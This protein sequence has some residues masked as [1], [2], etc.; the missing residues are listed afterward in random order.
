M[1]F[2]LI[3]TVIFFIVNSNE[4]TSLKKQ[5][6][7]LKKQLNDLKNTANDIS[8]Q[9]ENILD[10]SKSNLAELNYSIPKSSLEEPS[11]LNKYIHNEDEEIS[12]VDSKE[13]ED[14]ST[15][16]EYI[17]SEKVEVSSINS[18]DMEEIE[19][20]NDRPV[21]ETLMQNIPEQ[22]HSNNVSKEPVKKDYEKIVGKSFMSICASVLIFISLILFAQVIYPYLTE[23]IK[24]IG[25]YLIS[26]SFLALGLIRVK[27]KK[28]T[29][30]LALTSCG[31]G[32]IYIS[33]LLTNIYF[34][35]IND[36]TL[37]ILIMLWAIFVNYLSRLKENVFLLIGELGITI[38]LT[39]G[40]QTVITNQ[41]FI[42]AILL[43]IFMIV[44]S[45]AFQYTNKTSL[46]LK[47]TIVNSFNALNILIILPIIYQNM[48]PTNIFIP[49]CAA[50]LLF[51]LY[52]MV[53]LFLKVDV[54]D[55]SDALFSIFNILYFLEAISIVG[56]L[57]NI[58]QPASA[59]ILVLSIIL[60]AI[61]ELRFMNKHVFNKT[62]LQICVLIV[63]LVSSLI[64]T[65]IL[66]YGIIALISILLAFY[67][68]Y[69]ND[70]VFKYF[71]LIFLATL[72]INTHMVEW[73]ALIAGTITFAYFIYNIISKKDQYNMTLKNTTYFILILFTLFNGGRYLA[74]LNLSSDM[75][76]VILFIILSIVNSLVILTPFRKNLVTGESEET[77]DSI[78][79]IF[80]II[81]AISAFVIIL[82]T[83]DLSVQIISCF[84]ALNSMLYTFY[85]FKSQ[86]NISKYL[87]LS[88]L[89]LI[90]FNTSSVNIG[91]FALGILG[92]VYLIY[93]IIIKKEQYDM[94]FKNI[95][96]GLLQL[97]I[98]F[99]GRAFLGSFIES[100]S[101]CI[102]LTFTIMSILN[103]LMTLTSF[104]KNIT[105]NEYE[106]YTQILT[107]IINVILMIAGLLFISTY[108]G[109]IEKTFSILASLL[110]F[111]INTRS[112]L[113]MYK[114]NIGVGIY[115]GF[116]LT[117]L[118]VV[119][120]NSFNTPSLFIS[121]IC[122]LFAIFGIII[123][124]AIKYK[125]I[126]IYGL[127]LTLISIAKLM[128]FDIKYSTTLEYAISIFVCGILCFGVSFL[129][130]Y[131]DK[132]IG[133]KSSK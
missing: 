127:A 33:L 22:V 94:V 131:V 69:K 125:S 40:L 3:I 106:N 32:A 80:N 129:Y 128:L 111:L 71:S 34:K 120:L 41:D 118:L 86:D 27:K 31:L 26:F 130:N 95:T 77:T 38:A 126:R 5:M 119:I 81:L 65:F 61:T 6:R 92:F 68:F 45:L 133:S 63:A 39:F 72:L 78:V 74:T 75:I 96:Y 46:K 49:S 20:S 42:E 89:F 121:L 123:G 109:F 19:E 1:F 2:I 76:A 21:E 62:M 122:L 17:D 97:F 11:T 25:M 103:A 104:G 8:P 7:E 113:H 58:A 59:V 50:L 87:G 4:I 70:K 14:L 107:K 93:N 79:T 13:V 114:D 110:V 88:N 84:L 36:V 24:V 60:L 53:D 55:K 105:N 116:K 98:L 99:T 124:F 18:E 28:N 35:L 82:V 44:G 10:V 100:N 83:A 73:F 54:E 91:I 101:I 48:I 115:I 85:G 117:V 12:S 90:L 15:S 37:Y 102:V 16:N 52:N 29:L 66:T 30:N 67:G 57:I 9:K 132:L 23:A 64:N 112:L 56:R 47:D 43:I 51:I 108:D